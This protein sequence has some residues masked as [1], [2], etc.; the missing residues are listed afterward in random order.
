MADGS[1]YDKSLLRRLVGELAR[2]ERA[3][4][5]AIMIY[6]A[7]NG[8][9][10][11][12]VPLAAQSLVTSVAAT[13]LVQPVLVLT[14]GV[15]LA[16]FLVGIMQAAELT[17]T[18]SVLVRF[19]QHTAERFSGTP[20]LTTKRALKFYDTVT[21]QKSLSILLVDGPTIV[22]QLGVSLTLL[23]IY[24]PLLFLFAAAFVLTI[25]LF[26]FYFVARGEAEAVA[27]SAAKHDTAAAI[28][29]LVDEPSEA[30]QLVASATENYV[31]A[32]KGF[33]SVLWR[34]TL[35]IHMFVAV[36]SALFLALGSFLVMEG[37]LSLGQLVAADIVVALVTQNLTKLPKL[38]EK[39]YELA[40]ALGKIDAATQGASVESRVVDP[41][42]PLRL[43]AH[44]LLAWLVFGAL[45][46]LV[47]PWQQSAFS[48]GRVI[49][50]AP[51]DRQQAIEAPIEG[52]I[53]R[54]HVQEGQAVAQGDPIVDISDND[55][56]IIMRLRSEREAVVRRLEAAKR[57]VDSIDDRVGSLGSS[58]ENARNA[59]QSRVGMA[60]QRVI[61]AERALDA[62]KAAVVTTQLHIERQKKLTKEGLASTRT[63]ELAELD[64]Q[65][66]I[67]D[68]QRSL[69]ALSA[70]REEQIGIEAE[71]QRAD[72]D[73][74]ASVND[75]RASLAMAE[76]EVA[77]SEAELARVDVRLSRQS[78]QAVT[79]PRAGVVLRVIANAPG[80]TIVKSGDILATLVPETEDRAV[81]LFTDGM[82][83]PL[84]QV[85]QTVRLQ[86][87]G[88]PAV[89]FAGWPSIAVGTF[90]GQV[91]LVDA[92]SDDQG[93]LRVLVLP[94]SNTWPESRFLR[95][96]V[97]AQGW[98]LLAQ[99]RLGFEVWRRLNGFAPALPEKPEDTAG[100]KKK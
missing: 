44:M 96:G 3:T 15:L 100:S 61:A 89:Q 23:T 58:R 35:S 39:Y 30:T 13:G 85:G 10:A 31:H 25:V 11:L 6:A 97:R 86:F 79:A 17:L 70:A 92:A 60:K 67:L 98:V 64:H 56:E 83:A 95:Q 54:W 88:W 38:F 82:D 84:I 20:G 75:A 52:R 1:H 28:V 32:R 72:T 42:R 5:A 47:V 24:H 27:T 22:L 7:A 78:T 74:T 91:A 69:A 29:T 94:G 51:A 81:E 87:E 36:T 55:P 73:G 65:R 53:L 37:Q 80:G 2:K 90:G 59:A 77:V 19:F 21:V 40:A 4:L 66:A 46:M 18:E 50:Y 68:E 34:Q 49:A 12:A 71:R 9:V 63:V 41:P 62:S 48:K 26:A 14:L 57:R 45:A 76:A 8:V 93:R 16:L 33:F 99:V 43:A